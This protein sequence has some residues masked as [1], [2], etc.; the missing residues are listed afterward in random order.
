[1]LAGEKDPDFHDISAVHGLLGFAR[2]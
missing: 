1:V 2:S